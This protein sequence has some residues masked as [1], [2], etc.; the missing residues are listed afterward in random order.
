MDSISVEQCKKK[1][2]NILR[3][4]KW[5]EEK[6]RRNFDPNRRSSNAVNWCDDFL[7]DQIAISIVFTLICIAII[8]NEILVDRSRLGHCFPWISMFQDG[9][10]HRKIAASKAIC[11]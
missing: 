9:F 11:L 2:K 1:L 8:T 3:R 4:W 10:V 7:Q 5:L 6:V